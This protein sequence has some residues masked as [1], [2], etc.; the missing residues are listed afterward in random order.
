MQTLVAAF[1][2]WLFTS[3]GFCT[4]ALLYYTLFHTDQQW[5]ALFYISWIIFDKD[6]GETGGRTIRHVCVHGASIKN[7]SSIAASA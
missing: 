1:Y 7:S 2:V 6:V 3:C 5:V 4:T